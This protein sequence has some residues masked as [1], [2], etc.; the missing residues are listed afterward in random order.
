MDDCLAG[1]MSVCL[2]GSLVFEIWRVE[3]SEVKWSC[4][5]T[6]LWRWTRG[7]LSNWIITKWI[8][9][10]WREIL[11]SWQLFCTQGK[12]MPPTLGAVLSKII[13]TCELDNIIWISLTSHRIGQWELV[14]RRVGVIRL[15]LIHYKVEYKFYSFIRSG[16]V[17][18]NKWQHFVSWAKGPGQLRGSDMCGWCRVEQNG[19]YLSVYLPQVE[20]FSK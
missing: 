8:V 9:I 6:L 10:K 7:F 5:L 13:L 3:L 1:W 17:K 20:N 4:T 19:T 15:E 12:Q 11:I 18:K 2:A 14:W 16:K